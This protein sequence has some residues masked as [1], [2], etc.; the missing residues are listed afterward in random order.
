MRCSNGRTYILDY[1]GTSNDVLVGDRVLLINEHKVDG[2]EPAEV[3]RFFLSRR[4]MRNS[5]EA[6]DR[7]VHLRLASVRGPAGLASAKNVSH[8]VARER[9][10]SLPDAA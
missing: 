9:S 3:S 6:P 2:R 7:S 1:R 4:D 10:R 8:T 5:A